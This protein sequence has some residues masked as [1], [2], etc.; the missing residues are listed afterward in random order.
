MRILGIS[1]GTIALVLGV[2]VLVR[3]YGSQ[4]P[5]LNSIG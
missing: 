5:F 2:A 1:V 3:L 4:I